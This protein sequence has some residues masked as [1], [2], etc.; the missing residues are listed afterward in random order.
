M[1]EQFIEKLSRRL[2]LRA[3]DKARSKR[4]RLGMRRARGDA[5]RGR[6]TPRSVTAREKRLTRQEMRFGDAARWRD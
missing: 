5:I 4:R 2:L 3:R 1:N 6:D